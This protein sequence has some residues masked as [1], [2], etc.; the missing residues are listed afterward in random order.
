MIQQPSK[1]WAIT[2][3]DLLSQLTAKKE[4]LSSADAKSG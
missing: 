4:G 1:Y 3:P 2:Q